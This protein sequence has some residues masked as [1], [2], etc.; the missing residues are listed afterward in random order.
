MAEVVPLHKLGYLFHEFW[1]LFW[2]TDGTTPH[3][4]NLKYLDVFFYAYSPSGEWYLQGPRGEG[5]DTSRGYEITQAHYEPMEANATDRYHDE[6][7]NI[8]YDV[9]DTKT[10][11]QIV[12]IHKTLRPFL[13]AFAKA[14]NSMPSIRKALLWTGLEFCPDDV[15][16]YYEEL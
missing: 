1:T 4:P 3:W 11:F 6:I 16:N 13:I 15:Y 5:S 9:A 7:Y 12:P 14:A 2:P 10:Q 8:T